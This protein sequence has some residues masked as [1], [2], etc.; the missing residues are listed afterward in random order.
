MAT[1]KVAEIIKMRDPGF[2]ISLGLNLGLN[3]VPTAKQV[4]FLGP[5]LHC[6]HAPQRGRLNTKRRKSILPTAAQYYLVNTHK[7]LFV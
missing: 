1:I 3:L 7:Y 4:Y 6:K 2:P 5:V